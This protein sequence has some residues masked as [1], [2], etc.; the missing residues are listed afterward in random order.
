[1][2][3]RIHRGI[4]WLTLV[5]LLPLPIL[6]VGP[7]SVPA[8]RLLMLGGISLAVVLLESSKGAAPALA[9]IFLVQG[10]L[11]VAGLWIVAG[12]GARGLGR[13]PRGAATT[14]LGLLVA[15]AVA[16]AS[17]APIYH[18][19]YAAHSSHAGLRHLYE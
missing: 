13:L 1:M 17:I 14:L 4:L 5:G 8:A 12:L 10:L 19:P 16:L 18:T 7:G 15:G 9:A 6:V 3:H 2:S 11:Y